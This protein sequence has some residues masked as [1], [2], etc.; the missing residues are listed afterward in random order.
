MSDKKIPVIELFGPVYQGEG[1]LVGT[2]T[3][4]LRTGG[5]DYLCS[6][7][8]SLHAVLPER[9]KAGRVMMTQMEIAD[10]IMEGCTKSATSWLTISGGN[11][12]MWDLKEL[13]EVLQANNIYV[14]VETQGSVWRS[15]VAQCDSI[16]ISPK[17]PGMGYGDK[18]I[19]DVE[20][21][22]DKLVEYP[23]E[24][25]VALKVPI[26]QMQDVDFAVRIAQKW[27]GIQL[28]LSIGNQ[29]ATGEH[30]DVEA[31]RRAVLNW[32]VHVTAEVVK[33]PEL[34]YARLFPQQHVLLYG[35]EK[36]R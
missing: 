15:W 18:S 35:H 12:V 2:K 3:W 31:V 28:Y 8:D 14:A 7:C 34:M 29:V 19:E 27:P 13:I 26:L 33:R 32:G 4:F 1:P 20:A 5:C 11:P 24:E 22:L 16:V 25:V 36:G 23:V 30:F 17:G 6:Y 21:F 9:I 10:I